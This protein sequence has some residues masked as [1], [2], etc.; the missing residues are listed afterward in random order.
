MILEH[1]LH[2]NTAFYASSSTGVRFESWSMV[3]K[4]SV[5]TWPGPICHPGEMSQLNCRHTKG[6][7]FR[8]GHKID[9]NFKIKFV[10]GIIFTSLKIVH[11]FILYSSSHES[12]LRDGLVGLGVI[13]IRLNF[14]E[15]T[16]ARRSS[17]SRLKKYLKNRR[18]C[19]I[20]NVQLDSKT[21]LQS[22]A[23]FS[24]DRDLRNQVPEVKPGPRVQLLPVPLRVVAVD[25][26]GRRESVSAFQPFSHSKRGLFLRVQ[27]Q[28]GRLVVR[29]ELLGVALQVGI[30]EDGFLL[31]GDR[32]SAEW[33]RL[34]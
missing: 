8:T 18:Q 7:N 11:H 20:V 27:G 19:V 13:C 28:V 31:R 22:S 10:H 17:R 1:A 15:F 9:K 32:H 26:P 21:F 3:R 2:I 24:L 34:L 12:R 33:H 29:G 4:T 5:S 23:I 16:S 14:V 25:A 30:G 6:V